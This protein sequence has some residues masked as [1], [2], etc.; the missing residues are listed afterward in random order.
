MKFYIIGLYIIG[1]ILLL[2]CTKDKKRADNTPPN[3]ILIL[4]DDQGYGDIAAHGNPIVKTPHL[5][6]LHSES[7][8]FTDF[9]VNPFCAPTRAALM[10]GRMS[11]RTHVR[12]TVYARNHLNINETTM[13]E[14]FRASGYRTGH[15][16]KWHLGQNYPYRPIDRGFD[17]WVGHGDGGTG[18][19]SDYWGNDRMNDTYYRNGVQEKFAGF[20]TDVFFDETISFIDKSKDQPFFVYLATNVPHKPWNVKKEWYK[21]YEN[22]DSVNYKNWDAKKDFLATLTH[23]DSNLGKLRQY[24]KKNNLNENTIIIFLTDNGTSGG[25][26]IFNDGMKGKKGSMYEG[27]HR[28]PLF[29]YWPEGGFDKGIDINEFTAQIDLL[30]T[31]I[32]LCDLKSPVKGHLKFDGKSLEPLLTGKKET[33]ED[34]F[35]IMHQQ[36][37]REVPVKGMNSLVATREWRLIKGKELY[38]IR[39][40]PGQKNNL[41]KN[42]PEVVKTLNLK[43]DAY[44]DELGMNKYPFPRPIIGSGKDKETLLAP[45]ALIRDGIE[46]TWDQ[47]HI[48]V[49]VQSSGFWPV[50]IAKKGTYSFNIR[51]WPRELNESI[52]AFEL[53]PKTKDIYR[54]GK[55][56]DDYGYGKD[57]PK[58]QKSKPDT[59]VQVALEI[60]SIYKEKQIN[61]LDKDITFHVELDKGVTQIRAWFIDENGNKYG[62]YYVYATKQSD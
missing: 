15:F 12:S 18:S 58:I 7:M 62:A 52:N 55:L 19:A 44:W 20:G 31:L 47:S 21:D 38:Q 2:G 13:A 24:L 41:A 49:G 57:L 29:I 40:D 36:N 34:R 16:G 37:T 6:K 3:V 54:R 23:F 43:Y 5:D 48:E 60:G 35:L 25:N 14:F 56:V 51:R 39:T 42:F 10:T 53:E 32:N 4:T 11:D 46:N 61:S 8:R 59:I 17:H 1:S 45:D 27:G 30:P 22:V 26:E 28:V 33:L 9:H 50:E